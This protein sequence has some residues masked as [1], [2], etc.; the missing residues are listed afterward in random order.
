MDVKA[1]Q[2]KPKPKGNR[3]AG[4]RS[5]IQI[6]GKLI[7]KEEYFGNNL[8]GTASYILPDIEP[9]VSTVDGKPVMGRRQLREH[10]KVHDVV[11]YAEFSPEYI[12]KKVKER[13]LRL[14]GQTR[15]DKQDRIENLKRAMEQ[16]RS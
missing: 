2:M 11:Q 7:P 4:K 9:F 14:T 12:E 3:M 1:E 13:H 8:R 10:N 6:E 5:Y 16:H 15:E